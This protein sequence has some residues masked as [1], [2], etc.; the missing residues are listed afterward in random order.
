MAPQMCKFGENHKRY[1]I[2]RFSKFQ[3]N[4][5][6]MIPRHRADKLLKL[7][8]SEKILQAGRERKPR[9]H[10]KEDDVNDAG[11]A[12]EKLEARRQENSAFK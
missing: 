4:T 11:N 12:S 3:T 8:S 1:R 9:C 5:K 2:M 6:K 7:K 10:V